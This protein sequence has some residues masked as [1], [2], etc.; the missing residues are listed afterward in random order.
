[1]KTKKVEINFQLVEIIL[2]VHCCLQDEKKTAVWMKTK[3][4]NLGGFAPIDLILL[5][6]GKRV[7]QFVNH[8][9]NEGGFRK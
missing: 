5:G 1:M 6:K 8:A 9:A 7:L 4:F 3:N 2:G